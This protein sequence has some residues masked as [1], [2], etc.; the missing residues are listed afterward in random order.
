MAFENIFDTVTD[1]INRKRLIITDSAGQT[2]MFDATT[3]ESHS[4]KSTLTKHPVEDGGFITDHIITEPNSLIIQGIQSNNPPTI[5]GSLITTGSSFVGNQIGGLGGAALTFGGSKIGTELLNKAGTGENK[6]RAQTAYQ[7]LQSWKSGGILLFIRTGLVPYD[8][9]VITELG[10]ERNAQ[11]AE[12]LDCRVV[13]DELIIAVT[14]TEKIPDDL[15]A[16][17]A[18]PEKALGN[19]SANI[20]GDKTQKAVQKSSVTK[21]ILDSFDLNPFTP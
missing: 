19:E 10:P 9:M 6:N 1:F 12:S 7:M 4:D 15:I 18:K 14:T 16:D 21:S 5:L 13:F 17:S 11:N 20:A 2:L 8:N 3:N